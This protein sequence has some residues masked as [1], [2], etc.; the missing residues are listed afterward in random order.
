M[1]TYSKKRL[2]NDILPNCMCPNE[3]C[4][5]GSEDWHINSNCYNCKYKNDTDCHVLYLLEKLKE[6]ELIK[7]RNTKNNSVDD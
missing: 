7:I 6:Y 2:I 1:K 5:G 4:I 3:Y